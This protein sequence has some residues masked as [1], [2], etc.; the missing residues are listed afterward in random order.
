MGH[1]S[2]ASLGCLLYLNTQNTIRVEVFLLPFHLKAALNCT[3]FVIERQVSALGLLECIS[4]RCYEL[5]CCF[6]SHSF[7]N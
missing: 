4:L 1:F 2:P 6:C 5:T 7:F 3:N